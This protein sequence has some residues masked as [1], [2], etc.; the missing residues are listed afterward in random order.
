VEVALEDALSPE[1]PFEL[2]LGR[3]RAGHVNSQEKLLKVD[4]PVLVG[5][6][7]AEDMIAELLGIAR[8]EEHLVHVH[9]LDWRQPAVGAVLFEALVPFLDGVFVV[10]CVSFEKLEVLLGQALLRLDA[11]HFAASL[12]PTPPPRGHTCARARSDARRLLCGINTPPFRRF[13]DEDL[14]TCTP[15]WTVVEV[16]CFRM[17]HSGRDYYNLSWD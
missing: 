12:S 14:A 11:P 17:G 9:E 6:E 5:V 10:P 7:G 3:S 8:W 16:N 1:G 2:L 4:V 15:K 13:T